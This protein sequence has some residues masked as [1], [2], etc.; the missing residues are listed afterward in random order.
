MGGMSG[1]LII[2]ATA[3]PASFAPV[4]MDSPSEGVRE[5]LESMDMDVETPGGAPHTPGTGGCS[6]NCSTDNGSTSA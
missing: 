1:P 6:S 4:P 5:L 2:D 3:G